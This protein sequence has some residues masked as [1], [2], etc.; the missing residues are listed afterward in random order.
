VKQFESDV[1]SVLS[2]P[3]FDQSGT[4]Y[5]RDAMAVVQCT[6]VKKYKTFGDLAA[7]YYRNLVM[8]YRSKISATVFANVKQRTKFL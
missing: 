8:S 5:I 7:D 2:L 1:P 3:D 6:D 4:T